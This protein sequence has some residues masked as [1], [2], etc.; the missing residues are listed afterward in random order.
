MYLSLPLLVVGLFF[1]A[2]GVMFIVEAS[3]IQSRALSQVRPEWA[4][5]LW[6]FVREH[7][8]RPA[9]YRTT[10]RLVGFGSAVLGL[11]ML[12]FAFQPPLR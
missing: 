11:L 1:L 5:P 4:R 10:L 8:V 7:M 3:S 2:I 6:D 12:Y 9:A